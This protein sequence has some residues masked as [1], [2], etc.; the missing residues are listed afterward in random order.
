MQSIAVKSK[1]IFMKICRVLAVLVAIGMIGNIADK[2]DHKKDFVPM[3]FVW[4][5][6]GLGYLILEF[7]SFRE[8]DKKKKKESAGQSPPK[9]PF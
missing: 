3:D 6:L 5:A 8:V 2:L 7:L 1:K 4:A 9:E